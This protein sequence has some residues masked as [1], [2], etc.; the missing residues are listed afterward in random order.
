MAAHDQLK[1]PAD[2]AA[3]LCG[4]TFVTFASMM[5]ERLLLLVVG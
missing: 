3:S 5:A 4:C 1:V 2:E